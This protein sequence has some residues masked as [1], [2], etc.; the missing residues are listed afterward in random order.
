MEGIILGLFTVS[1]EFMQSWDIMRCRLGVHA[2]SE[3]PEV[4]LG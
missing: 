3:R 2:S 1:Q 4:A